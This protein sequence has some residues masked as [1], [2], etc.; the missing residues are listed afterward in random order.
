M[1]EYL[2]GFR[3]IVVTGPQRSGTRIAAKMIAYD[4]DYY[5]LDERKIF[6]DSYYALVQALADFEQH[7][8]QAPALCRWVHHLGINDDL[9]IVLMRRDI[10]DI[11][12]SQQRVEWRW[13]P[14]ELIFY[15]RKV[16]E[17]PIAEVKYEYWDEVQKH[18]IKNAFEVE[19]ESM[20][21]HP[22]WVP[23]IYRKDFDSHQTEL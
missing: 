12:A 7:V 1:F 8:I 17:G 13:E 14:L 2:D 11:I 16:N 20:R 6:I 22:L 18:Y 15:G 10:K 3:N 23:K 21:D 19:Y 4:L 9:A 5:F